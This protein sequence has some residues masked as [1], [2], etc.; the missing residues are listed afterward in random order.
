[1]GLPGFDSE[2][3]SIWD[4][5]P[6]VKRWWASA[7]QNCGHDHNQPGLVTEPDQAEG[8]IHWRGGEEMHPSKP[9]RPSPPSHN[10]W[11]WP[12]ARHERN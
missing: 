5:S 9:H 6:R 8:S 1:M 12:R 10:E 11:S 4:Q 2:F 3:L 7:G